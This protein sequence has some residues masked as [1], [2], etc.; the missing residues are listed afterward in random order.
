MTHGPYI[1]SPLLSLQ[2]QYNLD[3]IVSIQGCH[4]LYLFTGD[5]TGTQERYHSSPIVEE[6]EYCHS[7]VKCRIDCQRPALYSQKKRPPF[8]NDEQAWDEYDFPI[9]KPPLPKHLIKKTS[10]IGNGGG[11]GADSTTGSVTSSSHSKSKPAVD[12][13]NST[14]SK[15]SWI[16]G[17]FDNFS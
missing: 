4:S 12:H 16:S 6:C 7:K 14:R 8:D 9:S 10:K 2:I 15:G 1:H 17:F 11:G 5:G 13:S 3:G